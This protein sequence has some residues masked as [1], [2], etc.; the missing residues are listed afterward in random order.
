MKQAVH[1]YYSGETQEHMHLA[2]KPKMVL[3]ANLVSN[4]QSADPGAAMEENSL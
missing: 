4:P 1:V 3:G 2:D